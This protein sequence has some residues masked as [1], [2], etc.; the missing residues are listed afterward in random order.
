MVGSAEQGRQRTG[1]SGGGR[2]AGIA[3]IGAAVLALGAAALATG[4]TSKGYGT[5]LG[6]YKTHNLV[7]DQAGKA[8]VMDK[9]LVN[10]WGL[11]FGTKPATPAWIADNGTDVSTLYQG[12][13]AGSPV[14]KVPLTVKIP[15]GA[16]TGTVF[17]GSTSFVIKSG[18]KKGPANFLF[19]SEA[20]KITAWSQVVPPLTTAQTVA[21]VH[22]AI[23]KGLAIA[24]SSKGPRLYATDFHNNKVDV[25]DG[26][27]MRVHK[28]GAFRDKKLPKGYA[29]F[30][31]DT[32][33][34]DIVVTYAK[35]DAKAEDDV[36]GA[37]HGFVDVYSK[38]GKLLDR[39][40]KRGALNSPWGIAMAPKGF[41]GASGDLLIGNFGDGWINA[42]NPKT[43]AYIGA[44]KN[45]MGKP[46]SID[47]LWALEFG[48]GVIGTPKTLLFT[49][50]P[51]DEQHGLFGDIKPG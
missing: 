4:A 43:G 7:S 48:N 1:W 27:F 8:D 46:I 17:N 39:L 6:K 11:S 21:S 10:A 37:G 45:A 13:T 16:P 44:M 20:G 42:Y 19:S 9:S 36:S 5:S 31:I 41:G 18:A 22:G 40:V 24:N 33:K 38:G 47:G 28:K 50:G 30:G 35:Q 14:T 29:P 15:G 25:W 32:I 23:F 49:A 51:N 3:L 34:G 26:K 2:R 12:D